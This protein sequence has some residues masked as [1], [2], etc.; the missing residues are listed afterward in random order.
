MQVISS[1]SWHFV[2]Q[3]ENE[4]KER[5]DIEIPEDNLP[6]SLEFSLARLND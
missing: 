4:N 1:D 5:A 6:A 2:H 3:N